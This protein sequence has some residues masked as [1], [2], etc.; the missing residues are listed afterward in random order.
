VFVEKHAIV[1]I[2]IKDVTENRLGKEHI[3][4]TDVEQEQENAEI[5]D[6]M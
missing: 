5:I 3:K 4:L 1:V 2:P 6:A